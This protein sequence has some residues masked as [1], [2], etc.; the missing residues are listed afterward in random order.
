MEVLTSD[1]CAQWE[2]KWIKERNASETKPGEIV[3]SPTFPFALGDMASRR[4]QW[5]CP[6]TPVNPFVRQECCF[7][8]ALHLL[9]A[10]EESRALQLYDYLTWIVWRFSWYSISIQIVLHK[11]VLSWW[12][13]NWG[14]NDPRSLAWHRYWVNLSAILCPKDKPEDFLGDAWVF[15]ISVSK[16]LSFWP[17][18][19]LLAPRKEAVQA[20][21]QRYRNVSL[22]YFARNLTNSNSNHASL[23]ISQHFCQFED[24]KNHSKMRLHPNNIAAFSVVGFFGWLIQKWILSGFCLIFFQSIVAWKWE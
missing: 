9:S 13:K 14:W 15:F 23:K 21:V 3:A 16:H 17:L 20:P 11:C 19:L 12:T 10:S 7:T 5:S 18:L 24:H 4:W 1:H 6:F 22:Q 2:K 8:L